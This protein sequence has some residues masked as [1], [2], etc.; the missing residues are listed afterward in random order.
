MI[1]SRSFGSRV[2]YKDG[3]Q[4]SHFFGEGGRGKGGVVTYLCNMFQKIQYNRLGTDCRCIPRNGHS[5]TPEC[6]RVIRSKKANILEISVLYSILTEYHGIFR[7]IDS[8]ADGYA[9]RAR[10]GWARIN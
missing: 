8:R 9:R 10:I 4:I 5:T 2:E 7:I 3:F 6:G 1:Y